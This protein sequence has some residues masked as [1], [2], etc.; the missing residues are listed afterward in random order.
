MLCY[1]L[2]PWNSQETQFLTQES[3]LSSTCVFSASC[4]FTCHSVSYHPLKCPPSTHYISSSLCSILGYFFLLGLLLSS[5]DS[6]SPSFVFLLSESWED[7]Q[8]ANPDC[9]SFIFHH[10]HIISKLYNTFS[11]PFVLLSQVTDWFRGTTRCSLHSSPYLSGSHCLPNSK[12]VVLLKGNH[13]LD[14]IV[15]LSK[16]LS[17]AQHK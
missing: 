15:I 6:A 2:V 11:I 5:L 17:L 16:I 4:Q 3:S 10:A 14:Y 13:I 1:S 12:T 7:W 8:V 9:S